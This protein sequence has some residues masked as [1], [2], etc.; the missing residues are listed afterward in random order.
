MEI[1]EFDA[2]LARQM[3]DSEKR[4]KA[5]YVIPTVS[6]ESARHAVQDVLDDIKRTHL[7]A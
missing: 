2:I 5:D 1:E 3:P 6:L 7:H 4:A